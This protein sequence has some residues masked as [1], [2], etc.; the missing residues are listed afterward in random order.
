MFLKLSLLARNLLKCFH[1]LTRTCQT[2]NSILSEDPNSP[3]KAY[4]PLDAT[5]G[6]ALMKCT[7]YIVLHLL[8]SL[9]TVSRHI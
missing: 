7:T 9:T 6:R 8:V 1:F 4:S 5:R 3:V 2:E